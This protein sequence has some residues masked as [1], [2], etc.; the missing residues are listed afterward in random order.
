[1]RKP[2]AA[3]VTSGTKAGLILVN[4]VAAGNS[5]NY[6]RHILMEA[7]TMSPAE[8]LYL[9]MVVAVFAVFAASLAYQSW[10]WS[11]LSQ[12]RA[13]QTKSQG[14]D[15]RIAPTSVHA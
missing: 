11:R 15:A 7:K 14:T 4:S 8:K 2:I 3:R 13:A 6:I 1:L 10:Q 5:F 9:L 12:R